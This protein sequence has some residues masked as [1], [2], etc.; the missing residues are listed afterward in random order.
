MPEP[1]NRAASERWNHLREHVVRPAAPTARKMRPDYHLREGL[2]MDG[3]HTVKYWD[4]DDR[5]AGALRIVA[6]RVQLPSDLIDHGH[7][8]DPSC[9]LWFRDELR[10][11]YVL[12]RDIN[13]KNTLYA[14]R[15]TPGWEHHSSPMAGRPVIDAGM[16]TI[17]DGRIAYIEHKS[18]HYKPNPEQVFHTLNHLTA[19]G[20]DLNGVYYSERVPKPDD[21]G[22]EQVLPGYFR[23]LVDSGAVTLY[24]AKALQET[25]EFV[26]SR[27]AIPREE[28][29]EEV[30]RLPPLRQEPNPR[31]VCRELTR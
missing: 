24:H 12:G 8:T 29:L 22:S 2:A 21:Y 26:S 13:K 18:G 25:K 17:L 20:V 15:H 31:A 3:P 9:R 11:G 4:D 10:V 7:I 1:E 23:G 6:G 27:V 28:T 5:T 19:A 30:T 14:F 16:M